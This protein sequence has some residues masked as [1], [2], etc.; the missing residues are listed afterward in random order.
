MLESIGFS[1]LGLVALLGLLLIGGFISYCVY[2]IA[3]LPSEPTPAKTPQ[4]RNEERVAMMADKGRA[5][6]QTYGMNPDDP[7]DVGT[8]YNSLLIRPDLHSS[9]DQVFDHCRGST[10]FG[11]PMDITNQEHLLAIVGMT[12]TNPALNPHYNGVRPYYAEK[13]A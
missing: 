13:K 11:I 10:M 3:Q 7:S 9:P 6:V 1:W 12:S 8:I 2:A 5:V 4:E